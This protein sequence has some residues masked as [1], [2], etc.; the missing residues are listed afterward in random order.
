MDKKMMLMRRTSLRTLGCVLMDISLPV[1]EA[2]GEER[3]EEETLGMIRDDLGLALRNGG[4][5]L[6]VRL[7]RVV[8]EA[9]KQGKQA[10]FL[11]GMQ[12]GAR[13]ILSLTGEGADGP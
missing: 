10:G 13:I 7:E 6:K 3:S 1:E 11:A 2:L 8:E 9:W 5:N 12:A 4:D